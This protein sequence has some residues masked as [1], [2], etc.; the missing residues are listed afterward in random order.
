MHSSI[1]GKRFLASAGSPTPGR[2]NVSAC[3][4]ASG[5]CHSGFDFNGNWRDSQGATGQPA[6]A[7]NG[8]SDQPM[9]V[10][11]LRNVAVTAP[12]MHDGRF[13]TLDAV[14]DHYARRFN[15]SSDECADVIAFLQALTD[16]EF[17][18]R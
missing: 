9:R 17:S 15:L 18:G 12:Y 1:E 11:T 8:A 4:D 6:F 14:L 2:R 13:A 7:N 16:A 3:P 10:P 5:T